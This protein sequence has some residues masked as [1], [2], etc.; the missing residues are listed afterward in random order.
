M[1]EEPLLEELGQVTVRMPL[2]EYGEDWY[3]ILSCDLH[4][5]R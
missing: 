2:F 1:Q 5:R 3:L 4:E